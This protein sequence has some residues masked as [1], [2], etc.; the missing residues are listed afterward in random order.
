MFE[1]GIDSLPE[2]RLNVVQDA[3]NIIK[4]QQIANE[5]VGQLNAKQK[6][7][8]NIVIRTTENYEEAFLLVML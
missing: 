5:L 7:V 6:N 2:Y 3:I 1:F 4:K 8:F